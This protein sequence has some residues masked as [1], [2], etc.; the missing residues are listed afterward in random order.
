MTRIFYETPHSR[1]RDAAPPKY[2]HRIPCRI[3]RAPCAVHLQESDLA[4]KVS[5]LVLVRLEYNMFV[6]R[7]E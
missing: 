2:L 5:S 1:P 3:L 6:I 4:G 7:V